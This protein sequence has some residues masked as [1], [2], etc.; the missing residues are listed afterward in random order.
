MKLRIDGKINPYYVQTLCMML[1]PGVKFSEDELETE[2]L[3]LA[4]WGASH[5]GF[6]LAATTP[7]RDH[8][9]Y[10][11]DSAPFKQGRFAPSSHLPIVPPGHFF[12]EPVDVIMIVA[13]GYSD[14]IAGVIRKRFGSDVRVL[15]LRTANIEEL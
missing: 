5:Q 10:I 11:I 6:T 7:I 13:P 8:A 14:E 12:E 9:K 2:N 3:S 15:T 4:I 1:F